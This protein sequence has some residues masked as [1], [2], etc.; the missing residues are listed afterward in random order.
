[1]KSSLVTRCGL[2]LLLLFPVDG[3]VQPE[4]ILL[5]AA[6]IREKDEEMIL[7]VRCRRDK[8]ADMRLLSLTYCVA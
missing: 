4:P 6:V 8:E 5:A 7:Q 2:P 3:L 1:M